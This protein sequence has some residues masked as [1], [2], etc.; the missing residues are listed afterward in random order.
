V[1]FALTNPQGGLRIGGAV[2]VSCGSSALP[3]CLQDGNTA[4]A[5]GELAI[6]SAWAWPADSTWRNATD[7]WT[8][9]Y[10][11]PVINLLGDDSAVCSSVQLGANIT[12]TCTTN[13]VPAL[14]FGVAPPIPGCVVST[15]VPPLTICNDPAPGDN[16]NPPP[17]GPGLPSAGINGAGAK[18][19]QPAPTIPILIH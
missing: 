5:P 18:D 4:L 1:L 13:P 14:S 3:A 11:Y 8:T 7:A 9:A 17:L 15:L 19:L 2:T 12:F 6:A 10:A 16:P